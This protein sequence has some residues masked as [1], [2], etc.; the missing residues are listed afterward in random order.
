MS[1]HV[2]AV[3]NEV[4]ARADAHRHPDHGIDFSLRI[5]QRVK[6]H[7]YQGKRV[8]GV[9]RGLSVDD[10]RGLIVSCFLDEPIVIAA[11]HGF[12]ATK[13]FWQNAQAHEFS[14][15]DERDEVIAEL[16]AV[17][18]RCE[19]RLTAEKWVTSGPRDAFAPEA[20]L[21]LDLRAAITKATALH[22]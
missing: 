6:H 10:E 9:V 20:V 3:T 8:T 19:Q 11:G 1:A 13:I 14:P 7:D 4:R 2:P 17:V 5:G 21:L 22:H 18:Q 16:L 15:F 12:D